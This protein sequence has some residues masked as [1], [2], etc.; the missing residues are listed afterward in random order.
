M[1][2]VAGA[3]GQAAAPASTGGGT[4][5][6]SRRPTMRAIVQARYGSAGVWQLKEI[7]GCRQINTARSGPISVAWHDGGPLF[8]HPIEVHQRGDVI[9]GMHDRLAALRG[10]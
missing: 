3:A 10:R 2:T 5:P 1:N 9:T 8:P 7:G 6:A 4:T